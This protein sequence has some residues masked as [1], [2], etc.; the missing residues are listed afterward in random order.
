MKRAAAALA[1]CVTALAGCTSSTSSPP[2]VQARTTTTAPRPASTVSETASAGSPA[3]RRFAA[4]LRAGVASVRSAHFTL[5]TTAAG[6]TLTGNGDET[7]AGAVPDRIRL[8]ERLSSTTAVE[9]IIIGDTAY[10]K[11]PPRIY[12][13]SKP[14]VLI[15]ADSPVTAIK[16]LAASITSARSSASL[17]M[18][19]QFAAS[20]TSVRRDGTTTVRSV[21]ATRYAIV[22]STA[23]LPA[24]FPARATLQNVGV[25]TIPVEVDIDGYGRPVRVAESIH[26]GSQTVSTTIVLSRLNRAVSIT[27]PPADQVGT[28]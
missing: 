19:N 12:R 20:A 15:S 1:G 23:A 18:I 27:A 6:H 24:S 2:A 8:T 3:A 5:A 22:V 7:L 9:L 11:L 26:A 14:W 4:V 28:K 21:R 13:T 16:Q 25:R 17:D 10:A